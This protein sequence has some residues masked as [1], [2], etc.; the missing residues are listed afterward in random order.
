MKIKIHVDTANLKDIKN[1]SKIKYIKGITTNPSLMKQA[2]VKNYIS[3]A[4]I[5]RRITKKDISLEVF[6][7]KE[8][9]ILKEAKILHSIS[10]K[11]YI[12]IPIVNTNG[13][14]NTSII[15]KV[16]DMGIKVNVTAIFTTS[17]IKS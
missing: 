13:K 10:K 8:G 1:Y 14:L 16:L 11:F 3:F 4:K 9:G 7:D 5:L 6:S 12:K 17:Q 15:R 2:K